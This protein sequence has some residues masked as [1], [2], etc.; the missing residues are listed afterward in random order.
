MLKIKLTRIGKKAQPQYHVVVVEDKTNSGTRSVDN[1]GYY[2][3]L[4][5]PKEFRLDVKSYESWMAKGAR[6]TDTV[7]SLA[8]RASK[9]SK[10]TK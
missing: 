7:R 10:T 9:P 6:P 2:N 3:P 1:I 5:T 8:L 4:S